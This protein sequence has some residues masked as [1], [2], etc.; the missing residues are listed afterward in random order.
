MTNVTSRRQQP[1]GSALHAVE[2][3]DGQRWVVR[4]IPWYSAAGV[5]I[6]AQWFVLER[7][8]LSA[9]VDDAET[10]ALELANHEYRKAT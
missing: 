8:T 3:D 6:G 2:A 7:D 4:T 9:T 1:D 5:M 10:A